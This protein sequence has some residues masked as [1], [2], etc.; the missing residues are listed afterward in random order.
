MVPI[1]EA[2]EQPIDW[3]RRI[4]ETFQHEIS[5]KA[6]FRRDFWN[7]LSGR[8]PDV[9]VPRNTAG[10][11]VWIGAP[12]ADL[13]VAP[14]VASGGVGVCI[15]GRRNESRESVKEKLARY[16]GPLQ[17]AGLDI[18]NPTNW[19]TY[20]YRNL[21]INTQDRGN[22]DRATAWLHENIAEYQSILEGPSR[23]PDEIPE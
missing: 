16:T 8:Y 13:V 22:W 11:S 17:A 3:D 15:R 10:S 5:E 9:G 20:A 12:R 14:Y 2:V 19:G 23:D 1:F 4:R 18:S 7:H 6:Q 21:D